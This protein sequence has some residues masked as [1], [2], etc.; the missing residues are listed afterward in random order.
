MK[1]GDNLQ[2]ALD[3]AVPGDYVCL[4]AGAT[5]VGNYVVHPVSGSGWITVGAAPGNPG[6]PAP[7]QRVDPTRAG[8][9]PKLVT[10][11]TVPALSTADYSAR[12]SFE[13]GRAHV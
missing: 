1:A 5:F 9:L 7:G 13:I 2:A 3:S 12:W 11:N 8:Q 10:P 4:A 6:V